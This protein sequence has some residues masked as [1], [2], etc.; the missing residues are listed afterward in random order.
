[1]TEVNQD[2][3]P[4]GDPLIGKESIHEEK[5]QLRFHE[6]CG[7]TQQAAGKLA[8]KFNQELIKLSLK[9]VPLVEF[10]PVTFYDYDDQE[11]HR[12][13][14]LV[15]KRLDVTRWKKWN[16]NHGGVHNQQGK[17]QDDKNQHAKDR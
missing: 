3:V 4:V 15:E 10:L 1:M 7:R 6:Q 11:G 8:A 5:D 2:G 13:S 12:F 14:F 9:N 17:L 16:T